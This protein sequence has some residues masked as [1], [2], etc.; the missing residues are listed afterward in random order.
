MQEIYPYD[1]QVF[2]LTLELFYFLHMFYMFLL[3]DQQNLLMTN[4][5][6][7]LGKKRS[8]NAV[9]LQVYHGPILNAA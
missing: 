9:V 3:F 8:Q 7:G 6:G 4:T 1:Y 5:Q 2:Y